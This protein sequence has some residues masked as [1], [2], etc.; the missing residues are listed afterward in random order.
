MASPGA[1]QRSAGEELT[2]ALRSGGVPAVAT[3]LLRGLL[4][5]VVLRPADAR[6]DRILGA[7]T[8]EKVSPAEL[9][10]DSPNAEHGLEYAATPGLLF[11]MILGELGAD[12]P[13]YTFVDFGSGKGRIVCLAALY[14]FHE[15][16]GVEFARSLHD[17]AVQN[18]A[19]LS[20]TRLPRA[21]VV[22]SVLTDATEFPIP[23][24]DCVFFL[25]NP[26]LEPVLRRVVENIRTAQARYGRKTYVIYYN[27]QHAEVFEQA[28]FLKPRL[29]SLRLR[30]ALAA[31]SPHTLALYE[32]P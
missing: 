17:V 13:G 19:A 18:I 20:R 9:A 11:R 3:R 16:I 25:Y 23:D 24:A 12:F 26:F 6:L 29:L 27:P 2:S 4:N 5:R 7:N 1:Q 32:T 21:Q 14:P 22:R 10:V 15:V 8:G 31:A 30:L 28:G